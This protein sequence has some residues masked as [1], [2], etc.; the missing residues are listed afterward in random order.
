[1]RNLIAIVMMLVSEAA[2]MA[3]QG[4]ATGAC[5]RACLEGMVNRHLSAMVAHDAFFQLIR[6]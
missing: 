6:S 2:T 4:K 1:M 3:A 5:D